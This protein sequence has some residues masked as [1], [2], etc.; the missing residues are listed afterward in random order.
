MEFCW[1]NSIPVSC[2]RGVNGSV[3]SD[4]THFP[5]KCLCSKRRSSTCILQVVANIPSLA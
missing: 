2:E 5:T 1:Q 3:G 4:K